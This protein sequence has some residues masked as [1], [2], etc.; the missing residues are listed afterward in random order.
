MK[1]NIQ[2]CPNDAASRVRREEKMK[3]DEIRKLVET[4][5]DMVMRIAYQ[6]CFNKSDSED[7]TQE[8]FIKLLDNAERIKEDES[9]LKAWLIRVTVNLCRD[10]NKSSWYKKVMGFEGDGPEIPWEPEELRLWEELSQL[11]PVY[12]NIIYLYY[13]EGYKTGEIA[14]ILKLR[15]NTV[16]SYLA[17]ARKKLK[18][19]LEREGE[20][21]V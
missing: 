4:Y 19:I 13:Y 7:I 11:K 17:R 9:Y 18:T 10:Y 16:S 8:V 6:N 20:V 15:E 1:G 2:I 3:D 5:S 12:R 21:Y 14:G